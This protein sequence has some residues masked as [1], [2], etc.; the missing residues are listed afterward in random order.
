MSD[1][2]YIAAVSAPP[3]PAIK[4]WWKPPPEGVEITDE[5]MAEVDP[6]DYIS[7]RRL[8][9]RVDGWVGKGGDTGSMTGTGYRKFLIVVQPKDKTYKEGDDVIFEGLHSKTGKTIHRV[10][11]V[12]P[13]FVYTQGINNR[14]GDGWIPIEKV[15][16]KA[17]Y[18]KPKM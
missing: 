7:M 6:S 5:M 16:G 12:K 14:T 11:A 4:A 13:G 9:S 1:N 3:P 17:L 8:A 15:Y 10:K 2:A 18:P